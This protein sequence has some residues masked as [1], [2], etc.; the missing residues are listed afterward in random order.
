MSWSCKVCHYILS[1]KANLLKHYRLQHDT[2]QR[3]HSLPCPHSD[4]PCSFKLWGALRTHLS[5]YHA[6]EPSLKPGEVLSFT[7][8]LCGSHSHSTEKEYFEHIGCHLKNHETVQCVFSSCDFQTNI[9]GTF[10]SHK[11]RKHTPHLLT[12]FKAEVIR[13]QDLDQLVV[14]PNNPLANDNVV[15]FGEYF[16]QEDLSSTIV[17]KN[18]LC[19]VKV[20]E[21]IQC[22]KQMH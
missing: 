4:C 10:A 5:R 9:Y 17:K 1:S 7:C 3:N 12:D 15:E 21:H 16:D 20:R 18:R 13:R 14:Q 8:H 6:V 19:I 22:F 2:F 11:S